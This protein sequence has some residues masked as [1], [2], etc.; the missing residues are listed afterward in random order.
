MVTAEGHVHAISKTCTTTERGTR[1]TGKQAPRSGVTL[2]PYPPPS[3]P[4]LFPLSY[5]AAQYP[6]SNQ[7]Q[8]G[9]LL[10]MTGRGT[11]SRM[12]RIEGPKGLAQKERRERAVPPGALPCPFLDGI[13]VGHLCGYG[14][15][16]STKEQIVMSTV[17]N[18]ET[19]EN[20]S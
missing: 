15:Q 13:A 4:P 16:V 19:K 11:R 10:L 6:V 8:S 3:H 20:Q 18:A 14:L 2:Y 7:W 12:R 1:Q 5:W 17:P 9:S